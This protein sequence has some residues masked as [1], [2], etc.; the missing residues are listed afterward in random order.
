MMESIEDIEAAI[1]RLPEPQTME[2]F[3][4]RT[5][6]VTKRIE[7]QQAARKAAEPRPQPVGILFNAPD[8]LSQVV[9]RA[10]RVVDIEVVNGKRMIRLMPVELRDLA[11]AHNGHV[12]ERLNP[13]RYAELAQ[14]GWSA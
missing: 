12:W 9:T 1:A 6:L 14:G 8:G 10:G 5:R 2:E 3:D 4:H 7:M 13:G 11:M